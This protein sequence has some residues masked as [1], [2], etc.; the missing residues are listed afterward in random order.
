VRTTIEEAF[1]RWRD[2]ER[3][4][5]VCEFRLVQDYEGGWTCSVSWAN[6]GESCRGSTK[7]CWLLPADA[8]VRAIENAINN[9]KEGI[10]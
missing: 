9:A 10:S 6:E 4:S 7:E 2:I 3:G 1:A 5:A 8:I